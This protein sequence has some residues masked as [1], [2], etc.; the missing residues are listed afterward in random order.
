MVSKIVSS[1]F[2]EP[3]RWESA[4]AVLVVIQVVT[5]F[6]TTTVLWGWLAVGIVAFALA[7]G[8]VADSAIGAQVGTWFRSIGVA[9]RAL[10]IIA[11]AAIVWTVPTVLELPMR[12]IHSFA[13]GGL[14]AVA[15]IILIQ[16]ARSLRIS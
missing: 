2:V 10:V 5:T 3:S 11:F 4:L 14:L 6:M 7:M 9:G 12:P 13:T 15:A 16:T 1:W 8:P